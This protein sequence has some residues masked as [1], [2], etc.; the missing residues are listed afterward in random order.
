M[1]PFTPVRIQLR[2]DMPAMYPLIQYATT[3]DS[4]SIALWTL[5]SGPPAIFLPALP[6]ANLQV[7]WEMPAYRRWFERLAERR[8]VIHYDSRGTGLS[9]RDVPDLSLDA[10]LSDIDAVLARLGIARA[11]LFAASYAVPVGIRY[12]ATRPDAI[13]RLVLWCTHARHNEVTSRLEQGRNDQRIA[14]NR[15]AEVDWDLYIR[16]YLHRAIGW[17][18]GDIANQ[19]AALAKSSIE[20]SDFVRALGEY[21]DFDAAADLPSVFAPTLVL[22]RPDFIGSNVAVAKGLAARIPNGQL[23]LLDG[24]SVVPFI[25]DVE[26]VFRSL[27]GFLNEGHGAPTDWRGQAGNRPEH[28]RTGSLCTILFTEF[29]GH[30]ESIRRLGDTRGRE[31]LREHERVI[32]TA[33]QRFGGAEI[34]AM[35]EGFL[36]SFSSAQSALECAVEIQQQ[37]ASHPGVGAEHIRV[38]VGINAGEP[39]SEDDDLFGTAVIATARIA[40]EAAAGEIVVAMVVRELVAGKG[41]VFTDRGESLL[42]GF[43]EPMRLFALRWSTPP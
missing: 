30:E 37:F 13:S 25:G 5:G 15:L 22:H 23:M 19:L 3:S 28:G 35:G 41:F 34:K 21:A 9:D 31:L 43:P 8:T 7:E 27:N 29:D 4:V 16:T 18:Q 10:H 17:A 12:A 38:R 6:F 1:I 20:P 39:I 24:D 26:A 33:L 2:W 14:V 40:G 32:R 36:A 42:R 11:D